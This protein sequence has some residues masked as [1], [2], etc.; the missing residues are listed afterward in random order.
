MQCYVID[1]NKLNNIYWKTRQKMRSN[2][3]SN[4]QGEQHYPK[5]R[6]VV[7]EKKKIIRNLKRQQ[8]I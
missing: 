4:R 6:R 1:S 2:S 3:M 8:K 7:G 5:M